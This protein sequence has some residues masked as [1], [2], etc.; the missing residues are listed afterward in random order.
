MLSRLGPYRILAQIGEGGMGTVYEAVRDD[1]QFEQRVAIKLLRP[2]V[3]RIDRFESERRMLAQLRHP[4]I[5][6]LI[7]GGSVDGIPYIVMELVQGQPIDQYVRDHHLNLN[8]RLELFILVCEAVQHAHA[9]LIVHR[10]IK[11]ANILVTADGIPKLLDFGIAKH[12]GAQSTMIAPLTPRYASPEQYG[13]GIITIATDVYSLGI[14]LQE[15]IEGLTKPDDLANIVAMATRQ[16]PQR[17]YGSVAQLGE[18]IRR[19]L[20]GLMVIARPDTFLYRWS[21]FSRRNRIPLALAVMLLIAVL[22]G[23]Y[24]VYR[25]GIRAQ[26]RFDEV[27]SLLNS[28]LNEIDAEAAT[29]V[30]SSKV[31]RIMV[32]KSLIYLNRLAAESGGDHALQMELGRAYHRVGDIQGHR[33]FQNLGLYNESLESHLKGIRIEEQLLPLEPA[34]PVL[35]NQLAWGYA[36]AAELYSLRGDPDKA[37]AYATLAQPLVNQ[38]D[39]ALFVDTRIAIARVLH[40]ED[41]VDKALALLQGAI[42]SLSPAVKPLQQVSLYRWASDEAE[43]LGL[44]PLALEYTNRTLELLAGLEL[45]GNDITRLNVAHRDRGIHYSQAANPN[46]ERHCEAIPELQFAADGQTETLRQDPTSINRRIQAVT[47]LQMLSASQ[48]LC[49][50]PQAIA[51]AHAAIELYNQDKR[52]QNSDLEW[53]L[54]YAHLHLGQL[55]EAE[56]ALSAITNPDEQINE[57][58]GEIAL[59]KGRKPE[60]I[61]LLAKARTQ[62]EPQLKRKHFERRFACYRQA[63]NIRIALQ[64]GDATPGLR[65]RGLQLLNE[66]PAEGVAKSIR[67]L[68][69]ELKP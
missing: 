68:R 16:E 35:R 4:Y 69:A 2:G 37:L 32:E 64:A 50:K 38:S 28:V 62:R 22:A 8:H 13:G 58:R 10:D 65:E 55:R 23:A 21:K 36:H 14:L 5:A 26:R 61:T 56:Q 24:F 11:P 27:H 19:Y 29:V 46:E 54:A 43:T 60:A 15:L 67:R 45:K 52:R 3:T 7:D 33:R 48:A 34:N 53:H 44:V 66:F 47:A 41:Q 18:D 30:G 17:R 9:S 25:E 12:H 57:L 59:A 42:Q 6:N 40:F 51:T 39:P 20:D 1:G 49:G 31:R 63:R